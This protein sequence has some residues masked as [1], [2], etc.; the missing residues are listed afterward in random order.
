M[1]SERAGLNPTRVTKEYRGCTGLFIYFGIYIKGA[2]VP[3]L[4][5]RIWD[6]FTVMEINVH[7]GAVV[8]IDAV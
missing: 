4:R 5:S 1:T 7:S 8:I 2:T 6:L 3:R